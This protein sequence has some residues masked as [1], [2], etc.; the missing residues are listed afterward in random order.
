MGFCSYLNH[1]KGTA[2]PSIPAGALPGT[3]SQLSTEQ[4]AC[5]GRGSGT[6]AVSCTPPPTV[7]LFW[8]TMVPTLRRPDG[9]GIRSRGCLPSAVCLLKVR[10]LG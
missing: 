10:R 3:G 9:V 6:W 5:W 7:L 2:Y 1:R 4:T 8:A